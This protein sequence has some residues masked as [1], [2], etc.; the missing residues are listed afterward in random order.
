[1]N[2]YGR[3]ILAALVL[4][5]LIELVDTVF[6]LRALN[7]D[8][9]R[10]MADVCDRERYARSQAYVRET[11]RFGV[12]DAT[13]DLFLVLGFWLLG[14]FPLLDAAVRPIGLG[15]IGSGL[16]FIGTLG[17]GRALLSIPFR[18]WFTFVVEAR[19]GFNTTTP[20]LFV[21][22]ILKAGLVALVLGTPLTSL[23]MAIFLYGGPWAWAYC[24][25]ATV[26]FILAVQFIA[27]T[28]ILPIFYRFGPLPEG[29]LRQEILAYL[30][31]VAFPVR[32]V[33]IMDGSRR[34]TKSNAFFTGFGKNKR[35]AL[36]DTLV[37]RHDTGELVA[38]LAHEVGHYKKRHIR[39]TTAASFAHMGVMLWLLSLFIDSPGLHAAFFM[40]APAVYAGLVFFSLLYLPAEMVLGVLANVMSRKHEFE[41]DRFAVETTGTP[42]PFI[43]ALK[44]LA[45]DNMANLTPHPLHVF[46]H[47]SHPPVLA[48]IQALQGGLKDEK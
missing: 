48:R 34:S 43:R 15:T 33:L 35:I 5:Y 29:P 2:I 38:V 19:Y 24:W 31:S 37:D 1:M 11:T 12:I 22:D 27:P 42:A 45:V 23:V 6:Q 40:E 17:L 10:E 13:W 32:D 36:F 26:V 44:K 20:V 9:P 18:A 7:Q 8:R 39:K 46:L 41:A 3:I 28:W 25:G 4:H 47:A 21:T 16:I 30:A 14:G